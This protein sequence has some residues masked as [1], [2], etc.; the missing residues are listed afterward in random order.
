VVRLTIDGAPLDDVL[1]E[2]ADADLVVYCSDRADGDAL[3]HALCDR[4]TQANMRLDALRNGLVNTL[5]ES[6]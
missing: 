3:I 2:L 6:Q 1:A 4:L 5:R